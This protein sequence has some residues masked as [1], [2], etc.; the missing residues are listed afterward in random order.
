MTR[1]AAFFRRHKRL[2]VLLILVLV[3]IAMFVIR[4]VV[5]APTSSTVDVAACIQ[6]DGGACLLFPTVSG[7]SLAGTEFTLPA[8]F[9]G[10]INLV[11]MPFDE[12][13]TE[14]AVPWLPVAQALA[15]EYPQ[16]AYY[17]LPTLKSFPPLV[18]G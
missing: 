9:A 2:T 12:A 5:S 11:I 15:A 8:D 18:R 16:F 7:T 14:R 10:A 13:Q 4:T 17:D 1:L 6:A 3:I